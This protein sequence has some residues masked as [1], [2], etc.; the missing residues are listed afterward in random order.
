MPRASLRWL[1]DDVYNTRG[2]DS[3]ETTLQSLQNIQNSADRGLSKTVKNNIREPQ[4]WLTRQ[5]RCYRHSDGSLIRTV[6]LAALF[7]SVK[8]GLEEFIIIPGD[9]CQLPMLI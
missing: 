2:R 5:G 9:A 8:S 1:G 3:R 7:Q 4:A 6:L